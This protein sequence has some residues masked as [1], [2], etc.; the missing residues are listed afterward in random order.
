MTKV[1]VLLQQSLRFR[2]DQLTAVDLPNYP[3]LPNLTDRPTQVPR[4]VSRLLAC[5]SLYRGYM[6]NKIISKLFKL[7][8]TSVSNNII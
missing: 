3:G 2:D 5:I 8:P 1:V 7:S 4:E 6:W